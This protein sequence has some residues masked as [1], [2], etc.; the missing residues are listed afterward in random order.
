MP[1]KALYEKYENLY[2]SLRTIISTSQQRVL[3]EEHDE[4]FSSNVNFFVK[5]YMIN[6]CNYLEAFLQDIAFEYSKGINERLKKANIPHNYVYWQVSKEVKDKEMKF[7][8]A[9]YPVSKKDISDSLSANPYKTIKVFRLLGIDLIK[10]ETF[11]DNKELVNSVVVKRNNI[12]HH[13][14]NAMDISFSDLLSYVDVFL[15]YMKSINQALEKQGGSTYRDRD[16]H[17]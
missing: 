6:I 17:R 2:I 12:I 5:S 7:V 11:Q 3:S 14:D 13:N 8:D 4:L 10:E 16:T 1:A 15:E 9:N